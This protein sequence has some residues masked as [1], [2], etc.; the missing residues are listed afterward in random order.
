M[1]KN[2][3]KI[4]VVKNLTVKYGQKQQPI[5][6]NFNLEIDS[7]DHLAIIG[8]SGCGKT[9]FAKTLVN[10]LPEKATSKGYLSISSVDPRKINNKD[11]QLFRRNNFGFIYQDSIKKL[12]PLMRVGDHL[13]ELFRMHYETCLLYTS[14]SPRD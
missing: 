6:K 3:E 4:I 1:E 12:N 7:G 5:I 10:I 8:P 14:P 13:Y 2:K 9:T 11:A